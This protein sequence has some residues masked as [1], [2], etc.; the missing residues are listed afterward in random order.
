MKLN[1]HQIKYQMIK[2]GKKINY[3][4]E[5]KIKNYNYKNG[6]EK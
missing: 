1:S 2:S 4:K 3:T 6:S 5:S